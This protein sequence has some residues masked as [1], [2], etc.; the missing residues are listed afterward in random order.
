M[1]YNTV[2]GGAGQD[3]VPVS[4]LVRF[5]KH[6]FNYEEWAVFEAVAPSALAY[7]RELCGL[8]LSSNPNSNTRR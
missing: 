8:T 2:C 4:G 3:G 7:L 6:A 1:N 5:L